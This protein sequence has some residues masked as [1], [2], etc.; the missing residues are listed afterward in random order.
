[1][2][3]LK[4][5]LVLLIVVACEDEPITEANI[6]RNYIETDSELYNLLDRVSDENDDNEAITCIEFDYPFAIFVFDENQEFIESV[7]LQN[8]QEFVLLLDELPDGHSIS[9]SYPIT[10]TNAS[11]EVVEINNNEELQEAIKNCMQT[12]ILMECENHIA[13]LN[14]VWNIENLSNTNTNY[15]SSQFI[16]NSL[17]VGKFYHNGNIYFGTWTFL[18]INEELH[19]NIFV[20]DDTIGQDWNFDWKAEVDFENNITTLVNENG[21]EYKIFSEC[22][23][24]CSSDEAFQVCETEEGSGTADFMLSNYIYCFGN[25]A[26]INN[27][28]PVTYSFHETED[29]AQNGTNPILENVYNNTANPQDLYVRIEDI[30]TENLV[31]INYLT[32]EAVVCED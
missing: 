19:L 11:G 30:E 18:F 2:K 6:T 25:V 32:I 12:Q 5:L 14:C 27:A 17:G 20:N 23:L 13:R 8:D 9:I 7:G 28:N 21:D 15:E 31:V 29:D 3:Y 10:G 26:D 4:L 16:F 24:D 1:M 22:N